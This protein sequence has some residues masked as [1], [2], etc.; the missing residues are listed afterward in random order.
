MDLHVK[1]KFWLELENRHVFGEGTYKILKKIQEHGT[2]KGAATALGMSYRHAWGIL[3]KSEQRI[4]TPILT[5]HKGGKHGGGGTELTLTA[6]H[7]ME[8]YLTIKGSLQATDKAY[9]F[10]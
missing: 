4:G 1:I 9:E 2:L 7:L 6:R 3:K 10:V 8:Q 5:T